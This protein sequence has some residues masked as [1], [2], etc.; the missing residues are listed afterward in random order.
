MSISAVINT[1]NAEK[2]LERTLKTLSFVDEIVVA[3]MQSTDDTVKIA[4]RYGAVTISV[5]DFSYVEPARNV[6]ISS[7][8]SSWILLLDADESIPKALGEKLLEL[9]QSS[10]SISGYKIAR[11][12]IIFNSWLQS[13]GWWPDY[14]LRFFKKGTVTW[15]D[16]IHSQP[17]AQGE[18]AELPATEEFAIEHENY[19]TIEQYLEKFNRYTTIEAQSRP[20]SPHHPLHYFKNELFRRLFAEDGVSGGMHGFTAS[21]LQ[22]CYE[23]VVSLKH[24]QAQGFPEK[25]SPHTATELWLFKNE[26]VYWLCTEKIS[27]S[28]GVQM[29]YWKIRRK[30]GV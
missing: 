22:S 1:K 16:T 15:K 13:A 24:W 18:I 23:T 5:E 4:K 20:S 25:D 2:T 3:D 17:I 8:K 9:S 6:A 7:A 11:K 30:L 21:F 10:S 27:K 28:S 14:L 19:Q 29:I 26:L 12:N